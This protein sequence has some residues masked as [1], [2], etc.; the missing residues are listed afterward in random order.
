MRST[1]LAAL[2]AAILT[3]L[4]AAPAAAAPPPDV[5]GGVLSVTAGGNHA[6]AVLQNH[7]VR[8]W[9]DNSYGELGDGSLDPRNRAVVVR[10]PAGTGPLTGVASVS[11]GGG[12]TCALLVS[13]QVACWG[14]NFSGQLGTGGTD[15][16]VERPTIVSN[17]SG[18]S[19]LGGVAQVSAGGNS[20]CARLTSGQVRCWG[21]NEAHQ[22]GNGT[23]ADSGLPVAVS[24]PGGAGPLPASPSSM[25]AARTPA[26]DGPRARVC[27]GARTPSVPSAAPSRTSSCTPCPSR[28]SPVLLR[29]PTSD[30]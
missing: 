18:E 30:G 13:R 26:P 2:A 3:L 20:T 23:D 5:L 15:L 12:H 17:E 7:Q 28:P 10:N 6:C 1:I 22:L 11:A 8:C 19:V 9:G 25:S 29:S 21:E 4:V 27:A 14:D 24:A 16:Q